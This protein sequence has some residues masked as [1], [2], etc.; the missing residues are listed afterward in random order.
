MFFKK[1]IF[2]ISVILIW[3]QLKPYYFP[4]EGGSK[5]KHSL[6]GTTVSSLCVVL[7]SILPLYLVPS[8]AYPQTKV[9]SVFKHLS[10]ML[11]LCCDDLKKLRLEKKL[12]SV[13]FWCHELVQ[14]VS[15]SK[16]WSVIDLPV[17]IEYV[18]ES[19]VRHSYG[20]THG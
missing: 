13:E 19:R 6:L 14:L 1:R 18:N 11:A 8:Q 9:P 12:N 20:K 4:A 7:E 15:G 16:S 5:P 3:S 17:N 10:W 2:P